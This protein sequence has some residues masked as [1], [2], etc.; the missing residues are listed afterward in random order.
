MSLA[1]Q[2]TCD[3]YDFFDPEVDEI[4]RNKLHA[5]PFGSRR[6]WEFA[7]IFYL[8]KRSGALNQESRALALGAGKERLITAISGEVANVVV[9]DLYGSKEGWAGVQSG[10]PIEL[11]QAAAPPHSRL[12]NIV[13]HHMDMREIT[14]G[15]GEFDFCWSTGSFEHIGGDADFDKHLSEVYRVLK[16]GGVYV[17]TTA[18]NFTNTTVRMP[19]NYIFSP[20]HLVSILNRSPFDTEEFFDCSVSNHIFNRPHSE[21]I[22]EYG[23][24]GG[25]Y[26]SRPIISFRRGWVLT[27]NTVILY[28][29]EKRAFCKVV[30]FDSTAHRLHKQ[31]DDY[32]KRH[33]GAPQIIKLEKSED[34]FRTKP[35]FFGKDVIEISIQ[36]QAKKPTFHVFVDRVSLI[37]YNY[38]LNW[39]RY[40]LNERSSYN[41]AFHSGSEFA[42]RFRVVTN[43]SELSLFAK[44][45]SK[46]GIAKLDLAHRQPRYSKS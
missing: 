36:F 45:V 1:P 43:T 21:N 24:N 8:L 27:A 20:E 44:R 23:H 2:K 35:Q 28:K 39:M 7:M 5:I 17:F 9:T 40:D 6:L 38:E 37:E 22:D 11:I 4:I 26:F 25:S 14:Y 30:N 42:Y 13:A 33:W 16:P 12:D 10:S 29:R 32:L 34:D 18:I 41:F 3:V 19:H 31:A 46:D 15:D